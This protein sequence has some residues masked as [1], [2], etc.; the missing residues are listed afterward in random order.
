MQY[1]TQDCATLLAGLVG[2]ALAKLLS[3]AQLQ[4]WGWRVALLIGASIVPFGLWLRRSLPETLHA[5]TRRS[6]CRCD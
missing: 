1:A 6:A 2:V 5:A 4:D 3:D